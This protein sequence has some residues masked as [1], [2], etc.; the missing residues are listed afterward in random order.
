MLKAHSGEVEAGDIEKHIQGDRERFQCGQCNKKIS[1]KSSLK[2]HLQSHQNEKDKSGWPECGLCG[3]RYS[4]RMLVRKHILDVHSDR[5]KWKSKK[6]DSSLFIFNKAYWVTK[7]HYSWTSSVCL[8][9]SVDCSLNSNCPE[10]S[11]LNFDTSYFYVRF[12]T[13]KGLFIYPCT[14]K[15][16]TSGIYQNSSISGKTGLIVN[17]AAENFLKKP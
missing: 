10:I 11:N 17:S 6:S 1:R 5:G 13:L 12:H 4:S 14:W 9:G 8:H 2:A 15:R 7:G 3:K 16:W